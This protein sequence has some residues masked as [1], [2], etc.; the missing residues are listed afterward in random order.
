MIWEISL[1]SNKLN[2]KDNYNLEDR[3]IYKYYA[4]YFLRTLK[5]FTAK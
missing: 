5:L 3:L 4:I 2:D 1:Y